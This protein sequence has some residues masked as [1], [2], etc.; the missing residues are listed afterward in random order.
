[1]Q[2]WIPVATGMTEE[3]LKFNFQWV[4]LW[5]ELVSSPGTP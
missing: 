1:M 5:F 3:E 4:L 2:A